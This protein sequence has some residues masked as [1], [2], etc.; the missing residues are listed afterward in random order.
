MSTAM[1][2]LTLKP[3]MSITDTSMVKPFILT[4]WKR[5]GKEKRGR[6][7]RRGRLRGSGLRANS[8]SWC[9]KM[10]L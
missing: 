8:W 7:E 3:I 9:R 1:A 5:T 6:L 4:E 10:K 2:Q